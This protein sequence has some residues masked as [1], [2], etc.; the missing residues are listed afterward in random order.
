MYLVKWVGWADE[1]NSW[2]CEEH[3]GKAAIRGFVA[4]RAQQQAGKKHKGQLAA[5]YESQVSSK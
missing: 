4:E 5:A 1:H 3:V 2:V